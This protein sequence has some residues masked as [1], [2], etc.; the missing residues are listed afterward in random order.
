M[1]IIWK[2]IF[3]I[4]SLFVKVLSNPRKRTLKNLIKSHYNL[5]KLNAI[6]KRNTKFE[7]N[8]AHHNTPTIYILINDTHKIRF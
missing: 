8:D 3:Q 2:I 5:H 7:P 1:L 4:L 6:R